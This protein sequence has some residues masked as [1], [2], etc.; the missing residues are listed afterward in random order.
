MKNEFFSALEELEEKR[1]IPKAYMLEKVEAAL[2]NAFKKEVGAANV[3]VHIDENK[4]EVKVFK[5]LNVVEVVEDEKT[6]ISLEDAKR[7][8]RR[9]VLGG[10]VEIEMKTKNFGRISAQT[11]KQV[12]VQGIRQAEKGMMIKEYESKKE[13]VITAVVERIDETTG[14]VILNTGTGYATLLKKEQLMGDSFSVG[15]HVKVFIMEVKSSADSKGPLVTLSRVHQNFVKR[16]FELEVPEITD[17]TVKIMGITRE[18]GM[19][20]KIAVMSEEP[21]VD[22]VGSC[23]G[24][25]GIR[26]GAIMN[27]LHGEKI[28]VIRYSED[29]AEY[30]RSA[31][32]PAVVKDVTIEEERVCRVVVTPEQLSLAIGREGQNARLAARLTGYKID[33]KT[34]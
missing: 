28:D 2:V 14:N 34:E 11:A 9:N 22:A 7:M 27:E 13:D 1:G 25:R 32:S 3:R 18:A 16:L 4:G 31:L 10:V 29:P 26:V 24:A 8:S 19:R 17:G 5:Q 21:G 20:T 33:I 23:I 6:Q 15:D 30:I 12:I